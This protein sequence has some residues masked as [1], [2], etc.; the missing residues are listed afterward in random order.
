MVL[1]GV[2]IQSIIVCHY[3]L[4]FK[5]KHPFLVLYYNNT[6]LSGV[7]YFLFFLAAAAYTP[8]QFIA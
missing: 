6:F 5:M 4:P 2:N 3:D 7:A 8:E 1:K